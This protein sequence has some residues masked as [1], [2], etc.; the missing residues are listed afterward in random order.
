MS[1]ER[2]D[3]FMLEDEDGAHEHLHIVLTQPS[4]AGE[5]VTVNV[6]TRRRWTEPL[7]CI[8]AGEHPFIKVE[9]VVPFRFAAIRKCSDMEN[10]IQAGIARPKEKISPAL[11]NRIVAGLVDSDFTPPEVR[12]FYIAISNS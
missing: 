9:S 11:L 4:L 12:R 7:V 6:S 1:V 10:A 8:Q 3:T 2:G 5:V